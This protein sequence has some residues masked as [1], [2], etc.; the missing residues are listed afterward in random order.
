[1][2]DTERKEKAISILKGNKIGILS[3]ISASIHGYPDGSVVSY[4]VNDDN[5][6]ILMASDLADYTRNFQINEKI[7]LTILK[8]KS[9]EIDLLYGLNYFGKVKKIIDTNDK[10]QED[11]INQFP[12]SKHLIENNSA[13]LYKI[14]LQKIKYFDSMETYWV[15]LEYDQM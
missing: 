1:M 9:D 14:S 15:S 5:E 12:I 3:T 10:L 6:I 13:H 2:S 7:C 8:Q 4:F 11:Y